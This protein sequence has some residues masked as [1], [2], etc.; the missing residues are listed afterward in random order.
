M[1]RPTT[2]ADAA[3]DQQRVAFLRSK[4]GAPVAADSATLNDTNFP[5]TID[6]TT[7]GAINC[8]GFETI[9]LGVDLAGGASPT[10]TVE[11]LVRDADASNGSR[12]KR[13]LVTPA[14]LDGTGFVEV[15]VHGRFVYP[16][17][18]AVTGNPTAVTMLAFP[19]KIIAAGKRL[20]QT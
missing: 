3:K 17:I 6:A 4:T 16:R 14:T 1:A 7:G 8:R 9:W 10:V 11:M 19:G 12:W 5:P 18:S 15:Q 20:M 13:M 2:I